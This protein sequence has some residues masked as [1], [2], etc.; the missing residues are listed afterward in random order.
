[1]P[2]IKKAVFLST[3]LLVALFLAFSSTTAVKAEA[4]ENVPTETAETKTD[5]DTTSSV[6]AAVIAIVTVSSVI[7]LV[8]IIEPHDKDKY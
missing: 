5:A 2:A 3:I 4:E 8:V 6:I 7:M 1:M